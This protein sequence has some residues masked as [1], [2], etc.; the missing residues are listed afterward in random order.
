LRVPGGAKR[1]T[2]CNARRAML[3]IGDIRFSPRVKT[4]SKICG[5]H[6]LAIAPLRIGAL[7]GLGD[8]Y[9]GEAYRTRWS[10]SASRPARDR[11]VE[12]ELD[13]GCPTSAQYHG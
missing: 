2:K 13:T 7:Q 9:A 11:R 4:P 3:R 6:S 10:P 1:M 5:G 12:S 8:T